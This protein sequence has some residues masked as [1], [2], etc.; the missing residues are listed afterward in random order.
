MDTTYD[1]VPG[2]SIAPGLGFLAESV[3]VDN[4]TN[5]TWLIPDAN[6]TIPPYTVGVI[7]SLNGTQVGKVQYLTTNQ[8]VPIAGEKGSAT[9]YS[10]P[11][12]ESAGITLQLLPNL[13]NPSAS[14]LVW[15]AIELSAINGYTA[16]L[17]FPAI[18]GKLI[19]IVSLNVAIVNPDASFV[20]LGIF[21]PGVG[22]PPQT[23]NLFNLAC[24]PRN[25]ANS[26]GS[27]DSGLFQSR[28]ISD[29][30]RASLFV[31]SAV[32]PSVTG[33]CQINA[34]AIYIPGA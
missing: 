16:I 3:K 34:S 20:I 31:Y 13:A 19:R 10:E 14:G 6:I 33:K 30:I 1:L 21:E 26:S 9:F 5:Q 23:L 18:T 32:G 24:A 8:L 12:A 15:S 27:N 7:V 28:T 29:P 17:L 4:T 25:V 11:H 22:S 2:V